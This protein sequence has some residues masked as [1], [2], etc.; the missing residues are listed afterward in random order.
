MDVLDAV[1]VLAGLVLLLLAF[2]YSQRPSAKVAFFMGIYL[3]VLPLA[4]MLFDRQ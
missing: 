2:N 4:G 3:L 1:C